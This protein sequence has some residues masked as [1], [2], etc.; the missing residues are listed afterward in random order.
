MRRRRPPTCLRPWNGA[1]SS[2]T[3]GEEVGAAVTTF[4]P[5]PAFQPGGAIYEALVNGLPQLFQAS[6]G[7]DRAAVDRLD[8]V[9]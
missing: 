7:Y 3:V 4:S 9:A 6:T 5:D 8:A 2:Q 1:I